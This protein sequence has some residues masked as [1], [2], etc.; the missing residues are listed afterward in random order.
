MV[1]LL[2]VC[3]YSENVSP[4]R[5]LSEPCAFVPVVLAM[6]VGLTERLQGNRHF[7][8]IQLRSAAIQLLYNHNIKI[9]LSISFG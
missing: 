6:R 8:A 7:L 9:L 2:R 4:L 3:D 1:W 5:D